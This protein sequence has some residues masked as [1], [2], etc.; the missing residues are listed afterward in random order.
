MSITKFVMP[1]V[2]FGKGSIEQAGESCLRLG[3][4]KA[5]IVS[6]SGVANA[7]WLDKVIESC[8]DA[9]LAF[10]TFIEMTTNPKDRRSKP[11][12]WHLKNKNVMPSSVWAEAVLW[13]LPKG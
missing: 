1:E 9:G 8:Q 6:D 5:L 2:I 4:K 13:M 3:A 12:V 10:A 11:A 7:G